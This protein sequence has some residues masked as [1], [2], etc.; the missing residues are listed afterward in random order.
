MTTVIFIF[1]Y[2][3]NHETSFALIP[4]LILSTNFVC[5]SSKPQS[6]DLLNWSQMRSINEFGRKIY[7]ENDNS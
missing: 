7:A 6:T 5:H 2:V 3:G 1:Y 4:F